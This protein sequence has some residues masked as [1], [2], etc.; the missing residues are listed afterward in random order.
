ME[1]DKKRVASEISTI[2]LASC[3]SAIGLYVFVFPANFA[4]S[5]IDGIATMIQSL[6]NINAGIASLIINIPILIIAWFYLDRRYVVYTLLFIIIHS[7]M[8]MFLSGISFYQ[9]EPSSDKLISA[10][11]SGI[12]LGIRTGIMVKIGGSSGGM[13]IIGSIIQ[14][15]KPY[16]NIEISISVLCYCII[17][18][19]FFVYEQN[20]ECILLSF[21]QMFIFSRS[22]AMILNRTRNAIEVKI[23]TPE[24]EKITEDIIKILK[25]S[26]TLLNCR[27]LYSDN[28]K[29]IIL[30]VINIY[31]IGELLQ[32]LKKYPD[33]FTYFLGVN[34][35]WGNFRWNK[36]EIPR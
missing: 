19:S 35:V 5:G 32:V 27:G 9:Y 20:L 3:L 8:L 13:D 12:L 16:F 34:G 10:I 26:G 1:Y 6:T 11:F 7:I 4:P 30:C 29:K 2:L 17:G 22:M 14:R 18:I 24:Y 33:T 21:I 28:E 25:H 31:Q 23:I 15:K 36:N